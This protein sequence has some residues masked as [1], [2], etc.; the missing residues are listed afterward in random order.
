MLVR[1]QCSMFN[2]RVRSNQPITL[3]IFDI[4]KAQFAYNKQSKRIITMIERKW[5]SKEVTV[6]CLHFQNFPALNPIKCQ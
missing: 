1:V 3:T 6:H 2:V 4:F 5:S